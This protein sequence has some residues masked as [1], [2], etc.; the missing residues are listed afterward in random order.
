MELYFRNSF[1]SEVIIPLNQGVIEC[2]DLFLWDIF[3]IQMLSCKYN[4]LHPFVT[5]PHLFNLETPW[6]WLASS[7]LFIQVRSILNTYGLCHLEQAKQTEGHKKETNITFLTNH[8][9]NAF[10]SQIV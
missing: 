2:T 5:H 6:C 8:K 3:L 7:E 1:Y 9:W 4:F 10:A